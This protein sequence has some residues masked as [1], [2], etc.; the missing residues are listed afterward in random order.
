MTR[1]VR[2][3]RHDTHKRPLRADGRGLASVADRRSWASYAEARRSSAGIGLGFMLGGGIG[4]I[5]LD[6]CIDDR[7]RIAPWAREI[8]DRHR[9]EAL[10]I[11]KSMSGHGVH[12]FLPMPE[13]PGRRIRDGDVAIEIY[14]R[15]R[16]IATTGKALALAA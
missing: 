7:G 5:D 8:I 12:I 10:L 1:L 16:Y 14:S 9:D 15:S 2:W 6:H 4:A 13:Q 11:E 3:V